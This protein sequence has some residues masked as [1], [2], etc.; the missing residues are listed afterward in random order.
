MARKS[1]AAVEL[2]EDDIEQ[3]QALL[4]KQ[5][6]MAALNTEHDNQVRAV[7]AQ[8]GYQLPAD[9]TDPDLIQRDIAANMRRSVEACLEVGR[10][11]QVLKKACGHGE[12]ADRLEVLGIDRHVAARFMQSAAKFASLGNNSTLTKAIGNQTKLFE[13]L[14]LDDEEI[15]ELELTG[16]TGELSIDD[17]ATMSVKE[18]RKALR[19]AREDKKALAQVNADKNTKI[20]EL[21]AQL[22][23]KPLVV[24]Q[25]MDEQ[26]AERREELAIKATAA[27]AAIAGALH[28]AVQLLVEKGEESG[29][30]QRPIIAGMLAQVELALLQI[31]A[32][33]NIPATPSASATPTWMVDDS[34]E[35]VKAALAEA[36]K[37]GE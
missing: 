24:V 31:R 25:P 3:G 27:E 30:D 22:A 1:Q 15:Q 32:E 17:V 7:A 6:Q 18:L 28:P 21:A 29:Q 16:Q 11:L 12:F 37:Q 8:L 14:V 5:H 26:L 4:A 13:M 23:R 10:G 36:A 19:E 34:E 33:Y 20:D 9:C 35:A 2:L